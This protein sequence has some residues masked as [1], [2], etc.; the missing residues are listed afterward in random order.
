MSEESVVGAFR[1]LQQVGRGGMGVVWRAEHVHHHA[2]AAVKFVTGKR[3]DDARYRAQFRNEVETMA[4]LHHRS[5]AMVFDYGEAAGRSA[6]A[7]VGP[8]AP[9]LAMEWASGGTL[10]DLVPIATW[11]E[12]RDIVVEILSGLAHAH[13][14]DVIHRDLKPQNVLVMEDR[15]LK[16]ADFGLAYRSA[17]RARGSDPALASGGSP[18]WMAPEQIRGALREQGPWTDLYGVGCLVFWL[19]TYRPPY[20]AGSVDDI[21]SGHLR[22]PIPRLKSRIA[23]P[24]DIESWLRRLLAKDPSDRYRVAADAAHDLLSFSEKIWVDSDEPTGPVNDVDTSPEDVLEAA[25]FEVEPVGLDEPSSYALF[26]TSAMPM[27]LEPRPRPPREWAQPEAPSL[28]M[29]LVGAGLGLWGL[30]P[31]PMVDRQAERDTL[32]LAL[33]DVH[34]T[35]EPGLVVLRGAAGTGKTR[36]SRWLVERALELGAAHAMIARHER[37]GAAHDGLSGAVARWFRAHGL[38][39]SATQARIRAEFEALQHVDHHVDV[40][41]LSELIETATHGQITATSDARERWMDAW[42]R[43]LE[44]ATRDRPLVMVLDDVQWGAESLAFV[45]QVLERPQTLPILFVLTAREEALSERPV[46]R[47]RLAALLE[48]SAARDV[49]L[50]PLTDADQL[51]LVTRLLH[52][53]PPLAA[54]VAARS[55]GNALF[56]VQLTDDWIQRGLLEVGD[57]GFVL[58]AGA[59]ADLPDE[60]RVIWTSRLQR[61]LGFCEEPDAARFSIEIGAALGQS[62]SNAAWR[63]VCHRAGLPA[64]PALIDALAR[65][66]LIQRQEGGWSFCHAMFR[67]AIEATARA[68]GRSDEWHSYCADQLEATSG[69]RPEVAERH[70]GHLVAALRFEHALPRILVAAEVHA[71]VGEF[72]RMR[73]MFAWYDAALD[74]VDGDTTAARIRGDLHRVRNSL[75]AANVEEMELV[76]AA[77]EAEISRVNDPGLRAEAL[78]V[79]ARLIRHRGDFEAAVEPAEAAL[80][81][82]EGTSDRELLALVQRSL[83]ELYRGLGRLDEARARYGAARTLFEELGDEFQLGW[84]EF[85]LATAAKQSG[86]EPAYVRH[87]ESATSSFEHSRSYGALG[88]AYNEKGEWLRAQRRFEDALAVY[89]EALQI[90]PGKHSEV[91]VAQFNLG[92]VHIAT[93]SWDPARQW[94]DR[95]RSSFEGQGRVGALVYV[96]LA[97]LVCAAG[98][99]RWAQVEQ[100]IRRVSPMAAERRMSNQDVAALLMQAGD[101]CRRAGEFRRANEFWEFARVHWDRLGR[102]NELTLVEE[103]LLSMKT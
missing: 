57:D 51:D 95:A 60:L 55:Q 68:E 101:L 41:A 27:R 70:A 79:R 78:F 58:A 67:E 33:R 48:A 44:P 91:G 103:R 84:C 76:L 102:Q 24:H 2:A 1:L 75:F 89:A 86:D 93:E 36:L 92:L 66:G 25:L 15:R 82:L 30:R 14:R 65:D 28:P 35:R 43:Y 71:R 47:A 4:A 31:I 7:G 72:D 22:D 73:A 94:L 10:A 17:P 11:H 5:V 26:E 97:D 98:Q 100:L 46:E 80:R 42:L 74:L 64:R 20:H 16:L 54:E 23:V 49:R 90:L 6:P 13:A 45:A 39:A 12:V 38:D 81:L 34:R 99:R 21:L 59:S 87:L 53:S 9:Y 96:D 56:A 3:A 8:D 37:L 19:L 85:G 50:E 40:H 62:P 32:W 63:D 88:C 29:S 83:G 52:L 61:F 69:L 77:A 18:R